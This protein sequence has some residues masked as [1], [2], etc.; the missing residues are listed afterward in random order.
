M[1]RVPVCYMRVERDV[2]H[3]TALAERT[4]GARGQTSQRARHCVYQSEAQSLSRSARHAWVFEVGGDLRAWPS[5]TG[6]ATVTIGHLQREVPHAIQPTELDKK[7]V[8]SLMSDDGDQGMVGS[9]DIGLSP[10][11]V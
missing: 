4:P 10:L 3:D 1:E 11:N 9:L 6:N 2:H 8:F 7:S 5:S